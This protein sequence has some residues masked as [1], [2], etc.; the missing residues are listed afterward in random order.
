MSGDGGSS[1]LAS[2]GF[3]DGGV[4]AEAERE[5]ERELVVGLGVS[6]GVML[7]SFSP[8]FFHL[9][10]VGLLEVDDDATSGVRNSGV[11]P[12]ILDRLEEVV[13]ELARE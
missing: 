13:G 12:V 7:P 6:S 9:E 11:T 2:I 8:M 5:A 1:V 10:V 4:D 3:V